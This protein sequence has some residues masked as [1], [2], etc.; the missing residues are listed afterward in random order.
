[1]CR[2]ALRR[3]GRDHFSVNIWCLNVDMRVY[4]QPVQEVL[5]GGGDVN[6]EETVVSNNDVIQ[7][8]EGDMVRLLLRMGLHSGFCMCEGDVS[9]V[10]ALN[11]IC[12]CSSLR[13]CRLHF[14]LFCLWRTDYMTASFP[15][16]VKKMCS[17]LEMLGHFFCCVNAMA[18][19]LHLQVYTEAAFPAVIS[20]VTA[21]LYN[22]ALYWPTSCTVVLVKG[23]ISYTFFAFYY[24][25]TRSTCDVWLG[26]YTKNSHKSLCIIQYHFIPEFV[27]EPLRLM[28]NM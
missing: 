3:L 16:L 14:A 2:G 13:L 20:C 22:T 18:C 5:Q 23:A 25:Q 9:S 26:L 11:V 17:F 27:D 7:T 21:F 8:Q 12:P 6:C 24:F 15:R 28:Q 1:M 19:F 10:Q 4:R